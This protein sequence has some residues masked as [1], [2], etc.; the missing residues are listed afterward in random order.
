MNSKCAQIRFFLELLNAYWNSWVL[1]KTPKSSMK[2]IGIIISSFFLQE[3]KF[4]KIIYGVLFH[5]TLNLKPPLG[6][7]NFS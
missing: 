4:L 7:Q 2:L 1:C 6:A 5:S 3:I